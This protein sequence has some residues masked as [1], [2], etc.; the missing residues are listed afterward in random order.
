MKKSLP[1]LLGLLS[2]CT[3][4]LF[5]FTV[6]SEKASITID[7]AIGGISRW[8]VDGKELAGSTGTSPVSISY[9]S[10]EAQR[11]GDAPA[12]A[13]LQVAKVESSPK[14]KRVRVLGPV[15]HGKNILTDAQ[16]DYEFSDPT[17]PQLTVRLTPRDGLN[18]HALTRIAWS[19]PLRLNERKRIFYG[20]DRGMKWD[21]RYFYQFVTDSPGRLLPDPER[22]EWQHFSLDYFSPQA[23]HLWRSESDTTSPMTMQRGEHAP[24]FVQ[25]YDEE[26]GVALSYPAITANAPKSLRVFAP[27]GGALEFEIWPSTSKPLHVGDSIAR[28]RVFDRDHTFTLIGSTS[29][30]ANEEVRTAHTS[31]T[32][33]SSAPDPVAVLTE[34]AWLLSSPMIAQGMVTGGYPFAPS[35]L[36]EETMLKVVAGKVSVNAQTR[37][38]AFWPDGSVKWMLLSFPIAPLRHE[39]S[40][41]KGA[42]PTDES[43]ITFR[44]GSWLPI[45]ILP[46]AVEPNR[47]DLISEQ[48]GRLFVKTG[49]LNFTVQKGEVCVTGWEIPGSSQVSTSLPF[50]TA[51]WA[52]HPKTLRP[53]EYLIVGGT[54]KNSVFSADVITVDENGPD[55]AVVKLE[56]MAGPDMRVTLR[57]EMQAG[58]AAVRVSQTSEFLFADPRKTF[59]TGLRLQVPFPNSS[60]VTVV[61]GGDPAE[62]K[63]P[64]GQSY[65]LLQSNSHF[66]QAY[67]SDK[68]G[69]TQVAS[70]R[71]SQGWMKVSTGERSV[72]MGLRNFW[73][74]APK[75][76]SYDQKSGMLEA[77]IW[78]ADVPPMDVRRY[79]NYPHRSQGE[80]VVPR[81]DWVETT[82]YPKDPFVGVSRTQEILIDF[83][84]TENPSSLMADFQSPPLLYAG[85][86]RY[87]STGVTLPCTDQAEAPML[88]QNLDALT[89]FWFYHQKLHGWYGHWVYGAM[90]SAFRLGYGWLLEENELR[91]LLKESPANSNLRADRSKRLRDYFPQNDWAFDNGRW[92]WQNTE[93]LA[94]LFFQNQYLRTG[95]RALYFASN[96]LAQHSR[97]VVIR[98]SGQWFGSGTRHGVQPWSDGNHEERQTIA[99]E[100]KLNYFLSGDGR[101]RDVVNHLYDNYYTKTEVYSDAAHSARLYAM[102]MRTEMTGDKEEADLLK[103]YVDAFLSPEGIHLSPHVAF[104]QGEQT[105]PPKDL[106]GGSMF[107][108]TFGGMHAL[109]E[110][111]QITR[112][113]QLRQSM[114]AMAD[115]FLKDEALKARYMEGKINSSQ[116]YWPVL[117]FAAQHA[118]DPQKYRDFIQTYVSNGAWGL[119]YN[120]VTQN[121]EHWSGPTAGL[122][123]NVS[124]SLFWINWAQY[125]LRSVPEKDI[126]TPVVLEAIAQREKEGFPQREIEVSWQS[127]MDRLSD[128]Q[129]Y[130][131]KD[132]PW[133]PAPKA[134]SVPES[135]KE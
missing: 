71:N 72:L 121:P 4:P 114:I 56:G 8:V 130:L 94:N 97:D 23:F 57:L 31:I 21:T 68:A 90:P 73:P 109:V 92:G 91:R 39:N 85:W 127:E 25:V 34:D 22:N 69:D 82:Y 111:Y 1:A 125:L 35:E 13:T 118:D 44:D 134:P 115:S 101:T 88:W 112:D 75:A 103:K 12:T 93:G 19:L 42:I 51:S 104:P 7:P 128:L 135:A 47:P 105:R 86:K 54:R 3:I 95:N 6:E 74:M 9:L 29:A 77:L 87:A 64:N 89:R 59:L 116:I 76:I 18:D 84:P 106:N 48:D 129:Y 36:R 20:G 78:P 100:F 126:L 15:A 26:K 50:L 53:A 33:K 102:L 117:A 27:G 40:L 43:S 32:Q 10:P 2:L 14:G 16:L 83:A 99:S 46:A 17:R 122:E 38:L 30:K 52:H 79:S 63:F 5:A 61:G 80:S 62:I 70:G 110:Y 120:T 28:T 132:R 124:G 60:P 49:V 113:P 133:N 81:N 96:A 98:H 37:P 55:R 11:S 108:H 123:T 131:A 107:F 41:Q 65:T 58:S 24:G 119:A 67:I 45:R 66:Y